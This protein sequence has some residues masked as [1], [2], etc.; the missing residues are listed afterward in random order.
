M[1]SG[2]AGKK[3]RVLVVD[4]NMPIRLAIE[5]LLRKRGYQYSSAQN[6]AEAMQLLANNRYDLVKVDHFS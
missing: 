3:R 1:R 2:G 6:G 5:T 4:D